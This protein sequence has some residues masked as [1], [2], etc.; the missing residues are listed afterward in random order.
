MLGTSNLPVAGWG[1]VVGDAVVATA[2]LDR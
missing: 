2:T 1:R